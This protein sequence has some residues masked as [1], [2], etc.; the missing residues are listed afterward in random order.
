MT[1]ALDRTICEIL[2][3]RYPFLLLDRITEFVPGA[4]ISGIKR[5]SAND[6]VVQ[7]AHAGVVPLVILLEAVT[8]LGAVLVMERPEMKGK[9]AVILQIPAARV[10]EL[11]EPGSTLRLEAQIVKMRENFGELR[12][13]IYH[14]ERLVGEGQMRFGVAEKGSLLLAR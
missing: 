4:R 1:Q 14:E 6:E 12:G 7:P 2:P 11:I 3:H 5:F 9:V 10:H 8:Q 13:A